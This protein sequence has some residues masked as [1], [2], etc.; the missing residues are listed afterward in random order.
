MDQW[1]S[2]C[3]DVA[4]NYIVI[5]WTRKELDDVNCKEYRYVNCMF[6][7]ELHKYSTNLCQIPETTLKQQDP[8]MC[9]ARFERGRM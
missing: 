5:A 6:R 3:M 2:N 8:L 1:E 7:S 4:I 9:L